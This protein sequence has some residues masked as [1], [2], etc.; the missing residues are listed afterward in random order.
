MGDDR[1]DHLITHLLHRYLQCMPRTVKRILDKNLTF[2]KAVA[3]TII[4]ASAMH[5]MAHYYNYERIASV[6]RPIPTTPLEGPRYPLAALPTLT[7]LFFVK[8]RPHVHVCMCVCAYV[9][10]L[11]VCMFLCVCICTCSMCVF[12]VCVH[13]C[14]CAYVCACMLCTCVHLYSMC[15]CMCTYNCVCACVFYTCICM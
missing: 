6:I 2:H 14:A 12:C 4:A 5:T 3:W 15:V 8:V 11:C 13:M 9:R 7:L 10:V 1:C